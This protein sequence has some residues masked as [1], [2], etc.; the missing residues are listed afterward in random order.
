[1]LVLRSILIKGFTCKSTHF[2]LFQWQV[3]SLLLNF[4]KSVALLFTLAGLSKRWKKREGR[5][6]VCVGSLTICIGP[7]HAWFLSCISL[8]DLTS[9][10]TL[11]SR[12]FRGC[13]SSTSYCHEMWKKDKL[14][15]HWCN[16]FSE[17][18]MRW[19]SLKSNPII[20]CK[21]A[22][23]YMWQ[24]NDRVIISIGEQR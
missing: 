19:V 16:D 17:R 12:T 7:T 13:E 15:E 14:T 23:F 1:M 9:R 10:V 8:E 18:K 3:F 22:D 2:E 20:R 5:K 21:W 24:S 6:Y 4:I 11:A